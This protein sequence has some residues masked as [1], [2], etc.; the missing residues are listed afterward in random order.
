MDIKLALNILLQQF[1]EFG[2]KLIWIWCFLFL[3]TDPVSF[4]EGVLGKRSEA[5]VYESGAK[6]ASRALAR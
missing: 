2:L 6:L 4:D 3:S 5:A 1:L